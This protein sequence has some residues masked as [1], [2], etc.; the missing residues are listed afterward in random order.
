LET[1]LANIRTQV[2]TPFNDV[3]KG[4]LKNTKGDLGV[5]AIAITLSLMSLLAVYSSTYSL[6]YKKMSGHTEYYLLK[7]GLFLVVGLVLMYLAHLIHYK[8]YAYVARYLF[9]LSIPLLIYTLFFGSTINSGSRWISVLGFTI[10][11]SDV[12]KLALFMYLSLQLSRRQEYIKEFK[13]GY[14]HLIMPIGIIC[15]LILPANFSTAALLGSSALL[16]LFMGRA[17]AKHLAITVGVA[18]I[19]L[20]FII[21]LAVITKDN[22]NTTLREKIN[23][24]GTARLGTWVS[25]VQHHFFDAD[26]EVPYQVEQSNM[27]IAKGGFFGRGPGN[28]DLKNFLPNPFSDFIYSIIIEEYGLLGAFIILSL[29]MVLLYRCIRIFKKCNYAFGGFLVLGLSFMLI[30]QACANM[31]VAVNLFPV[32]GVSL[33]LVSMGGTSLFFT[34]IAFGIIL[35]VSRYMDVRAEETIEEEVA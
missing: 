32:T 26:N 12:A 2:L 8:W 7:Q 4:I 24:P 14:L 23:G 3:G 5:W 10:Q 25:R 20:L 17:N 1:R 33:P 35:S 29:Y 16:L 30:I 28:S 34:S 13:R 15:V 22:K 11:S 19:P 31:A 18:L 27:A 6:A 21:G 9:Y